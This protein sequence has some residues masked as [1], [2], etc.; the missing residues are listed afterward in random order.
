MQA[1]WLASSGLNDLEQ[2]LELLTAD[3]RVQSMLLFIC[4]NNHWQPADV[5]ALLQRQTKPLLGGVFPQVIYQSQSHDHGCLILTFPFTIRHAFI[6]GLSD[7][8]VDYDQQLMSQAASLLPSELEADHSLMVWV[9]G[10]SSRIGSLIESMF[11]TLGLNYNLFGG[12]AGSLTF[13]QKPCLFD[14]QG[15]VMDQALIIALPIATAMGVAHGWQPISEP[16]QVTSAKANHVLSLNWRPAFE[17]YRELVE[18]LA[19][20]TFDDHN[21]FDIAKAYPFGLARMGT[22]IIVR[23]PLKVTDDGQ[24]ICVGEVPEGSYVKILHGTH[25]T[26]IDAAAQTK[27]L[28]MANKRSQDQPEVAFLVNCISRVLFHGEYLQQELEAVATDLPNIGVMTLG[29]I[30]NNG[31]DFIEFYNKTMVMALLMRQQDG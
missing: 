7:A 14:N 6:I 21:F 8:D 4:D 25:Q 18:P 22:D 15:M 23:D 31:Q 29:E 24:M 16:L 3:P 5:D 19:K 10:L 12:G 30:A 26:L 11:Y 13:E 2:R 17:L 28:A 9:D 27:T 1:I 20:Q